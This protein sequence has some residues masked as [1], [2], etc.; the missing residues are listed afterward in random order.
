MDKYKPLKHQ[1]A[2]HFTYGENKIRCI[3]EKGNRIFKLIKAPPK[4]H[5]EILFYQTFVR[6]QNP[7]TDSKTKSDHTPT[8]E[9]SSQYHT[10]TDSTDLLDKVSLASNLLD[11]F[12]SFTSKFYGIT[13]INGHDYIQ[14]DN[15]YSDFK[16][17]CFADIKM[18]RYN[19]D[20]QASEEKRKRRIAKFPQR[21]NLG[22]SF[23][24]I[25]TDKVQLK[26]DFG[27]SLT[28]ETI[29]EAFEQFLP[30]HMPDRVEV[31]EKFIP[32]LEKL[33]K[34]FEAQ[35]SLQFYCSSLFMVYCRVELTVNVKMIDFAH[36]FYE[37]GLK[38]EN[39]LLGL[40]CLIRDFKN[41]IQ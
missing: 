24:G 6:I 26:K 14:L 27:R 4:G 39:Y 37:P 1:I 25:K 41:S 40:K 34:W 17:P 5:D 7:C 19:Y 12:Q 28:I 33:Q 2:G 10:L 8:T 31:V 21:L 18:G 38:D 3:L 36:V 35:N 11:E 32:K 30:S 20:P 29:A 23:S 15:L 13:T 16:N 9:T 22:Y